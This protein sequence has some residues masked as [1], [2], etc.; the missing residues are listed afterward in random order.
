MFIYCQP[1]GWCTTELF[2]IWIQQVFIPYEKQIAEKCLLILDKASVH[3]SEESL[4]FLAK[5]NI[6]YII[7]PPGMTPECQ[8]LDISVNKIFKD[9]IKFIFELNRIKLD[10]LNG[11]IK[12]KTARL[13]MV[14]NIYTCWKDD[15]LITKDAI[16]NGFQHAGIINNHYLSNEEENINNNYLYDI[17]GFN[18]LD[19]IDDLGEELN[20]NAN[21]LDKDSE[22]EDEKNNN[23]IDKF[24]EE[25][26]KEIVNDIDIELTL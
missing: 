15:N 4:S 23:I 16:I 14:E 10:K 18:N 25:Y 12:L 5:N 24:E 7:I 1:Q 26:S 3:V 21:E 8:P 13:H 22:S 11:K 6:S 17:F 19:I 2:C 20:I 9:A